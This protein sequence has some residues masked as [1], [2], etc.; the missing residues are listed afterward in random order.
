LRPMKSP[1]SWSTILVNNFTIVFIF[2]MLNVDFPVW[3]FTCGLAKVASE[4]S[5]HAKRSGCPPIKTTVV[6]ILPTV[7][8]N[9]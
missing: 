1:E 5:D 9:S 3:K 4:M 8:R 7:V 2:E 6:P